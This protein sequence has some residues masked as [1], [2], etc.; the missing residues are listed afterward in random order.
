MRRGFVLLLAPISVAILSFLPSTVGTV[1][2]KTDRQI[3]NLTPASSPSYARSPM[4]AEQLAFV[5]A[6]T[7]PQNAA[8]LSPVPPPSPT[9]PTTFKNG[10]VILV[11]GTAGGTGFQN[12]VVEWAPGL[13]AA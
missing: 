3:L 5:P 11:T 12:F 7:S 13:D 9:S 1:M 8:I 10:V 2:Q 6:S 4:S